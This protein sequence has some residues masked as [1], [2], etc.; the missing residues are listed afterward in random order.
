MYVLNRSLALALD[1]TI[2][3]QIICALRNMLDTQ[4][5]YT[6]KSRALS[7]N[8][9]FLVTQIQHSVTRGDWVLLDH[10]PDF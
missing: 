6:L 3:S 8:H 2:I 1:L 10:S 5:S 9:Y 4:N 7:T